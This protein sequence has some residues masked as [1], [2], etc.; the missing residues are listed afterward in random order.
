MAVGG[1][2][3]GQVEAGD[4]LGGLAYGRFPGGLTLVDGAADRAPGA[5]QVGVLAAQ[6]EQD[7]DTGRGDGE[8]QQAGRAGY[9]PVPSVHRALQPSA[10]PLK[11]SCRRNQYA[12]PDAGQLRGSGPSIGGCAALFCHARQK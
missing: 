4:F 9:T 12:D 1:Q 10:H 7:A 11:S 3:A 2:G 5:A 6:R 8:R